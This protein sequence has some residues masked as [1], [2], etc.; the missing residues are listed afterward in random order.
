MI[1]TTASGLSRNIA[2]Q[3]VFRFLAGLFANTPLTCAG[4]SLADMWTPAERTYIVPF[5][6][7]PSLPVSFSDNFSGNFSMKSVPGGW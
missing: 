1:F 4:G 6:L 2:E 7:L 5:S 3:L